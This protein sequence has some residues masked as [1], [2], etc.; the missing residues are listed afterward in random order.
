MRYRFIQKATAFF[1]MSRSMRSCSTSRRKTLNSSVARTL[2]GP[3]G[4]LAACRI[5]RFNV[6]W[7][8]PN[9]RAGRCPQS[10]G[11]TTI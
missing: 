9:S 10:Q 3:T 5:Q 4:A 7:E 2:L 1:R 6:D 8:I 11:K